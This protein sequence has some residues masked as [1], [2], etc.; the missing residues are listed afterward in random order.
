M[1]CCYCFHCFVLLLVIVFAAHLH[2][3]FLSNVSRQCHHHPG[4]VQGRHWHG[5]RYRMAIFLR[6]FNNWADLNGANYVGCKCRPFLHMVA[7][8]SY[9]KQLYALRTVYKCVEILLV[10]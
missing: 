6:S 8:A 10:L 7:I 4:H 1:S 5:P 2:S 9:H 3:D